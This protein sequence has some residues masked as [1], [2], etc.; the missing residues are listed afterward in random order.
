MQCDTQDMSGMSLTI[1]GLGWEGQCDS[2]T[3]QWDTKN[4]SGMCLVIPGL[5]DGKES[6]IQALCSETLETCLG[7]PL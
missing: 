6:R 3:V 2:D 1:L 5:W 7:C 4:M